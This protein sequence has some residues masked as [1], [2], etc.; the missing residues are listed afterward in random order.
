MSSLETT[1]A[2][3]HHESTHE[4]PEGMIIFFTFMGLL[5][6]GFL[7]E[8]NKKTKLP[9]TPM[10]L[11]IGIYIGHHTA[12]LGL[13]GDSI[14]MALNITPEGILMIFIPTLIFESGFNA[15]WYVFKKVIINVFLLAGPGVLIGAVFLAFFLKVILGYGDDDLTWPGALVL[16]SIISTTDPVAV[17]A[18]LK[19][20]GA[21]IKFNLLIEGESLFNDGT[22]MVFF[23]VFLK[24]CKGEASTVTQV[25]GNFL[26]L[27]GG[28]PLFGLTV[29]IVAST[30]LKRVTRD[31]ILII[32]ITFISCYLLFFLSETQLHVSGIL[33]LVTLGLFMSATGKTKI[34]PESEHAVH[35][36][37]SW[38]QWGCETLIFLM[39]GL[40]IGYEILF[41]HDSSITTADWIKMLI[42]WVLMIIARAMMVFIFWPIIKKHG[43]GLSPKEFIVLVWGGLRGAL[44]LALA[45]MVGFD[46]LLPSRMRDLVVFYMA[47]MATLTLLVNG[48]TCSILVK[49]LEMVIEPEIRKRL[50]R[51]LVAELL[52]RSQ[53]K[54]EELK[55]GRFLNVCDWESVKNIVG[56]DDLI[57]RLAKDNDAIS[58]REMT[59]LSRLVDRRSAYNKF[60]DDD[61][62]QET[63]FRFLRVMKGIVWEKY[64]SSLISG[65]AANL[66]VESV[67]VNLDTTSSPINLW[68]FLYEYF[69]SFKSI[70]FLFKIKDFFL[71]GR[72]AKRFIAGHLAFI[73]EVTTAFIQVCEEIMEME[74]S[75]PLSKYHI[76]SVVEEFEK[77]KMDATT[78]IVSL[79]DTFA[80]IIK[81]I[82]VYRASNTIL[83][84]QKHFLSEML[85]SG[86]IEEKEYNEL[87]RDIDR[88]LRTLDSIKVEWS[89]P[90]F[91]S[92][93]MEFPFFSMLKRDEIGQIMKHAQSKKFVKGESLYEKGQAI[94][95]IY[96]I[97]KGIVRET[98]DGRRTLS[99]G[100][101]SL[102]N[103]ANVIME[104]GIAVSSAVC[105]SDVEAYGIPHTVFQNIMN[106]NKAF[107]EKVYKHS[108]LSFL[109]AF[110]ERYSSY[111]R[112]EETKVNEVIR[113][114][115][116]VKRK[117]DE[118]FRLPHG[119]FLFTGA[120]SRVSGQDDH[121]D[122]SCEN[123]SVI[124]PSNYELGTT[125][126]TILL[127]FDEEIHD[128]F[129]V[130]DRK[131]SNLDERRKSDFRKISFR[132]AYEVEQAF[133]RKVMEITDKKD[134]DDLLA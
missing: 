44:G 41:N 116:L 58:E 80:D 81:A 42:F 70:K 29:G 100:I 103:T 64:E 65:E 24:M 39:T 123:F 49:K 68:P 129:I 11:A 71:I 56:Y 113:K 104:G 115:K 99:K 110:N 28:G 86:Q 106:S 122:F 61:I 119:G 88:K 5:L 16:G 4:N 114:A 25:V 37:W 89:A 38:I 93:M 19:E 50:Q 48:T 8:V 46:D 82:Q 84:Y 62:F 63:R 55:D 94:A 112:L 102:M 90:S 40:L 101:G 72:F 127:E 87:R 43:Y 96:I 78:Y 36:V 132:E 118:R 30:W 1:S 54:Q 47:G 7:R 31:N 66:L 95:T 53:A 121:K 10:L 20:M 120:I 128:I 131:G 85:A 75:I 83:E 69:T 17:V 32:A 98:F 59:D 73:Y 105:F 79:E 6:G 15:D 108:L 134:G 126:K 35:A 45:L 52:M 18:L 77:N 60:Q 2:G 92:F 57:R 76:K 22:A 26:R 14:K 33:A 117:E 125:K 91:N 23:Q 109:Y 67:N 124:F 27:A 34:D 12:S 74:A 21:S 51:N 3:E 133:D 107:E 111:V 97:T 9:Y 13:I 130:K